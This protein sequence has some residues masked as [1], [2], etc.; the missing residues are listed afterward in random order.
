MGIV[1]LYLVT[2]NICMVNKCVDS[3]CAA[4]CCRGTWLRFSTPGDYEK[5]L[6]LGAKVIEVDLD[7]FKVNSQIIGGRRDGDDT[8]YHVRVLIE[9]IGFQDWVQLY[10]AC[11]NLDEETN[12]CMAHHL[13]INA[14]H[15]LEMG[16]RVCTVMRRR[17]GLEPLSK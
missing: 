3:G 1:I 12:N 15:G 9:S 4:S 16:A 6:S 5:W 10:G 17:D 11:Q 14:C 8:A 2:Y 7:T 13:A